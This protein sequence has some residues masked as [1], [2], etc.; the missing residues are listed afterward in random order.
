MTRLKEKNSPNGTASFLHLRCSEPRLPSTQ[1]SEREGGEWRQLGFLG[2]LS[3][4]RHFRLW[5][6]K[7]HRSDLSDVSQLGTT[8]HSYVGRGG[9]I[10][11]LLAKAV[12]SESNP[13]C[14]GSGFRRPW[15]FSALQM[16]FTDEIHEYCQSWQMTLHSRF[17][18]LSD[19]KS[20]S[21]RAVRAESGMSS[22]TDVR[23]CRARRGL[24]LEP[25]QAFRIG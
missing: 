3:R 24:A 5:R 12:S 8:T 22:V 4:P 23:A 1:W 9:V 18:F 20:P 25:H 10:C 13:R 17:L 14:C 16:A 2:V 7:T 19:W 6:D 15:S 21:K 11:W